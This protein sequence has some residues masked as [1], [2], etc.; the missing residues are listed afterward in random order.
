MR[1]PEIL[2]GGNS[3]R[4]EIDFSVYAFCFETLGLFFGGEMRRDE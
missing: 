3:R 1:K 4:I 2:T